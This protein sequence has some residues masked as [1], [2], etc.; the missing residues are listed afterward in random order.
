MNERDKEQ[1]DDSARTGGGDADESV[2][3]KK[4]VMR[5]RSFAGANYAATQRIQTEERQRVAER[6]GESLD[7][8]G[9]VT[10]AEIEAREQRRAEQNED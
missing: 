10:D 7:E 1:H 9:E 4:D 6:G 2:D 3:Q 5:G 8:L